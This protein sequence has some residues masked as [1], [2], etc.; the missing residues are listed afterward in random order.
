M[1]SCPLLVQLQVADVFLK[2][3]E[4]NEKTPVDFLAF[5]LGFGCTCVLIFKVRKKHH[6]LDELR[7]VTQTLISHADSLREV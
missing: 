6:A 5:E 2:P 4:G 3:A 1:N 7:Q